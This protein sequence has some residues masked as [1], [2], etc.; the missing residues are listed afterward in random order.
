MHKW[1]GDTLCR[2]NYGNVVE[3]LITRP[4]GYVLEFMKRELHAH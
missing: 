3:N 4:K 2:P 1:T